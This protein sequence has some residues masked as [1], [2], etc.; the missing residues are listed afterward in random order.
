MRNKPPFKIVCDGSVH[1]GFRTLKAARR[2]L[3]LIHVLRD[4]GAHIE[5]VTGR[6]IE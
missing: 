3:L 1:V 5:D 6:R 4:V 2:E